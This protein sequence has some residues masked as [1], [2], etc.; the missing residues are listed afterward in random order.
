M[1][2]CA[3][4]F[5]V[6]EAADSGRG[7]RVDGEEGAA[8]LESAHST[9][10]GTASI[11]SDSIAASVLLGCEFWALLVMNAAYGRHITCTVDT[12]RLQSA[13]ADRWLRFQKPLQLRQQQRENRSV[14]GR[15]PRY[16]VWRV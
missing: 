15:V 7:G 11:G 12:K 5:A 1:C 3:C 2:A 6:F 14:F 8:G 9:A 10:S 13:V 16:S 4:A